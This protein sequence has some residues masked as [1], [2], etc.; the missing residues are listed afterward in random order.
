[1]KRAA[2]R[3]SEDD[4]RL[5]AD[6][7]RPFVSPEGLLL[8]LG[9]GTGDLGAGVAQALGAKVVVVDPVRQMLLRAPAD[10]LVSVRLATADAL[11]FPDGYFDAVLCSDAFH[12]FRDQDAAV[13][14]MARVVRPGGGVLILEMD[15]RG[16]TRLVAILERLVGEPA[17]FKTAAQLEKFLADRGIRGTSS[18]QRGP[19]YS[20]VGSVLGPVQPGSSSAGVARPPG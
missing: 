9:G 2:R 20:F 3:W 13:R 19:S 10:P 1:M 6:R 18:G 11:P 16:W 14:E 15:A 4:F 5:L 12:H 8:D 7:L 17:A